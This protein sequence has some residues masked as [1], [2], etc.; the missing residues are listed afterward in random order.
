MR[1]VKSFFSFVLAAVAFGCAGGSAPVDPVWGKQA[2]DSCKMIIGD[3]RYAAELVLE[4]GERRF[5]DD[6]G[7]LAEYLRVHG[8]AGG[9]WVRDE[10]GTWVDA[11][12][13][14]YVTGVHTPMDYGFAQSAA[15]TVDFSAVMASVAHAEASK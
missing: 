7:C 11:R 1:L 12:R 4:N 10:R 14:R 5:F 2:C 3:R 8:S 6:V 9:A 15:G 13:A